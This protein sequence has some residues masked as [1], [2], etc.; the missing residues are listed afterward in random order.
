LWFLLGLVGFT[1]AF[2]ALFI[3]A[4]PLSSD[5]LR[6]RI[7]RT[8]SD[9]L[10]SDV[11]LG[12]L[13]VRVFPSLRAE[14]A[15]LRIRRR[16]ASDEFPPLI[17]IQTFHVDGSLLALMAKHVDHV[18]VTGLTVSVPPKSERRRAEEIGA[19][20]SEREQVATTDRQTPRM[21]QDLIGSVGVVISR[22]DSDNA[23]LVIIPEAREKAP[24][25]WTI[26]DLTMY[27]LGA[28]K[29]WPFRATLTNAVP[30]GAIEVEGGFG[31][32]DRTEPGDT[33]L[34]GTFDFAN[35]DL[36][37]FNGIAGTLSSRG[38]FD[39]T[40]D[41]IRAEGATETPD[42]TIKLGGHPF[43]LHTKYRAIIDG[44]SG[45]T[46]LERID[47]AFLNSRLLASGAVIGT[48]RGQHGRAVKL[49]FNMDTARVEDVMAMA[50]PTPKPPM[51]GALKLTAHFLLPPG[52]TDVTQRLQLDGRFAIG[53]ATFTSL[54][55]QQ[56]IN[57]LS[58]RGRGR[59][60]E[61]TEQSV[62]SDFQGRFKLADGRLTLPDVSF[63][64][65]GAK[66][67][68]AGFYALKPQT[69]SFRGQLLIDAL[70]SQTMTGWKRWLMKP[71]DEIFRQRNG[72]G[73]AIP[74][75]IEGT[76]SDPKF[77]LDIRAALKRR[78]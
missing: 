75:K 13:H 65:P 4:V 47:A 49:D 39:G 55:I 38:T 74:I 35:A 5:A 12:D 23:R 50:V 77:G 42:F 16:G 10:D 73:S 76:R 56:K 30:P 70:V 2:V 1:L 33:P 24:K 36:S 53:R 61:P 63:A 18:Q 62:V 6:H 68:L 58:R 22:V 57:E 51:V 8:L 32:W 71:A 11:E 78:S 45:D 66:V 44:T 54:A 59:V 31:P 48:P 7:V 67:T 41:E 21:Q 60:K 72:S 26:H 9:K 28:A 43:A 20:L 40:L 27:E 3:A 34:E 46:R 14:G 17:A 64:V 69:L 25:V 15:D 52:E 37:V 29:S 19:R